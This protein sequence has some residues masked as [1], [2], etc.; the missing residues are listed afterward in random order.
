MICSIT[1]ALILS[2][3]RAL[4]VMVVTWGHRL[5]HWERKSEKCPT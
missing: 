4:I 1:L 3:G 5:L 2:Q